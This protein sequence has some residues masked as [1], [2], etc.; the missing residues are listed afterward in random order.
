MKHKGIEAAQLKELQRR[1]QEEEKSSATIEKYSRDVESFLVC[2]AGQEL[3]KETVILYKHRLMEHYAPSSV[4]SMLAAINYYFRVIGRCDC[5]VKALKIQHQAFRR[6]ER[7]LTREEYYRLLEAAR[8]KKDTRLYMLMQTLCATGMRV[9]ELRFVTV[10]AVRAGRAT[11]S[12]KG[13]TRQVLLPRELCR[14]LK[15]YALKRGLREGSIFVTRSGRPLDRSNIFHAM[16][17]L[18]EMAGVDKSKVFPHNLRHLFAC[19]YY[20]AEKDISRLA[21]ILGHANLNTTRI[22]TSLSGAEQQRQIERLGL[23]I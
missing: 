12:L 15:S 7:E 9:S 20:K 14:Q 4:N 22:Y 23:V 6:K 8:Q 10:A 16:R 18:C 11:V 2:T 19:M 13:K 1:M 17:M 21:D 3:S 5:V